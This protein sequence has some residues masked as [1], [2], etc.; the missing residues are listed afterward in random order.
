MTK[1]RILYVEDDLDSRDVFQLLL[2]VEGF[3]VTAADDAGAAIRLAKADRFDLYLVD[4]WMPKTSGEELCRMLREFDA[5]TPI[6]FYSGADAV[7][8]QA[9][10]I[11][12]G[13][14]AYLVKPLDPDELIQNIRRL[15]CKQGLKKAV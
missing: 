14:D 5:T 6:L 9:K 13:A 1:A 12:A 15:I 4:N 10:A 3:E 7:V 11:A 2:E 8:D